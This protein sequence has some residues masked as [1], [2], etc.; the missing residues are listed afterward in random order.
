MPYSY[1]T[2]PMAHWPRQDT[3]NGKKEKNGNK[4]AWKYQS[5]RK[6]C[7]HIDKQENEWTKTVKPAPK[8]Q[9]LPQHPAAGPV[10]PDVKNK[11]GRIGQ[12]P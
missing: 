7:A 6:T 4:K 2:F 11:V 1:D 9:K 3:Q 10:Y 8:S 5:T 12:A